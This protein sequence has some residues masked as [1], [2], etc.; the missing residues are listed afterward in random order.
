MYNSARTPSVLFR[1]RHRIAYRYIARVVSI[2]EG[3]ALRK[4]PVTRRVH[5]SRDSSTRVGMISSEEFFEFF[6]WFANTASI[7]SNTSIHSG[8]ILTRRNFD[9]R[10]IARAGDYDRYAEIV[11]IR[12]AITETANFNTDEKSIG[13]YDLTSHSRDLMIQLIFIVFFFLSSNLR[14][15]IM[16]SDKIYY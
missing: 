7:Y 13:K 3:F 4:Y 2:Y 16:I 14:C 6:A 11:E 15:L 1:L 8:N 9:S 12:I 10:A 5:G